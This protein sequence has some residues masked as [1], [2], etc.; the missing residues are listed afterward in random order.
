MR[1]VYADPPYLGCAHRYPEHPEAYVWDDP[2]SHIDL[3]SRLVCEEEAWAFS[4]TPGTL[5]Y[6][7]PHCPEA[8]IRAW[9]KP[10]AAF[11]KHVNPAR[12]WEPVLV[13]GGRKRTDANTY[14]RDWVAQ[15]IAL[16]K[17]LT[18]AKPEGF[19]FWLFDSV[20]LQPED[21]FVDLFPGSGQVSRAW[22]K[23]R[24]Q[25]DTV[26]SRINRVSARWESGKG[27]LR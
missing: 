5:R 1:F 23:Y 2:Q 24:D 22:I 9:V 18:G 21:T 26:A 14:M 13:G 7:L 6:V 19:C 12:A 25:Y 16:K 27:V 4:C 10:F 3:V 8:S 11:K 20:N 15:S 17:G